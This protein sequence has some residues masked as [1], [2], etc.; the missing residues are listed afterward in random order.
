VFSNISPICEALKL[1]AQQSEQGAIPINFAAT[2]DDMPNK[3]LDQL[4]CSFV[5]TQILK[6]I[7]LTI[8]FEHQHIEEFINYCRTVFIENAD[9]P[10][11]IDKLEQQYHEETPIWRSIVQ[12]SKKGNF[13]NFGSDASE[14]SVTSKN[15][16]IS[17]V[18]EI[19]LISQIFKNTFM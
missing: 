13:G 19:S 5:Y 2:D 3:N 14:S 12:T 9:N 10:V 1:T 16:V 17:E 8:K 7:L 18:F 15:L 6:E 4:N 11:Y